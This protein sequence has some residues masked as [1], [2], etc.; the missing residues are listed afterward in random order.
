MDL[1]VTFYKANSICSL[2][3]WCYDTVMWIG[4]KV[5]SPCWFQWGMRNWTERKTFERRK[6]A[7]FLMM[8]E[9]FR[10]FKQPPL[11]GG[12]YF[13]SLC[14]LAEWANDC[15][16]CRLLQNE[17]TSINSRHWVN[18]AAQLW[19]NE[20]EPTSLIL[21]KASLTTVMSLIDQEHN[22]KVV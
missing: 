16:G 22:H 10:L 7:I 13:T 20:W 11:A 17:K 2:Y 14:H 12:E 8:I 4:I 6:G 19:R 15:L 1:F 3:E 9:G 18:R 5:L 21:I